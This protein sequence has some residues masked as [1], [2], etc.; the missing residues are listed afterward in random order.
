MTSRMS[1]AR[2]VM[3]SQ[4]PSSSTATQDLDARE[5][6]IERFKTGALKHLGAKPVMLGAGGNLQRHCH[7]AIFGVGFKFRDFIQAVHRIQRF[8]QG[9]AVEIDIVHSEIEEPVA[10]NCARN[11]RCTT[12]RLSGCPRSS[13]PTGC[14]TISRWRR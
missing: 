12:S 11:G 4:D 14:S 2:S 5:S 8:G 6:I 3:R 7:R 13:A 1:G 9:E 10:R